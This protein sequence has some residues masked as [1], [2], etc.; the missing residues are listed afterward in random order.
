MKAPLL[1]LHAASTYCSYRAQNV[2]ELARLVG[3]HWEI[4]GISNTLVTISQL[5]SHD[6]NR[7][8]KSLTEPLSNDETMR[9]VKPIVDQSCASIGNAH[10][11]P[12]RQKSLPHVVATS[13]DWP[14]IVELIV[15]S[16]QRSV[17]I[18]LRLDRLPWGD[19]KSESMTIMMQPGRQPQIDKFQWKWL[20]RNDRSRGSSVVSV[21]IGG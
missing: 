12:K 1:Y 15:V 5:V 7:L 14:F 21:P 8:Q 17:Q 13:T 18:F 9:V 11:F 3:L 19:P 6:V 10:F 2:K 16:S 4:W 20:L